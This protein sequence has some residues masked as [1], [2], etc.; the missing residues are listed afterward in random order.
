MRT[1]ETPIE[2]GLMLRPAQPG[3]PLHEVIAYNQSCIEALSPAFTTLWL[4]DHFQVGD[5]EHL[6]CL[7]TLTYLAALYPR[8]K[9]GSL[10]LGQGYRNPA[11]LAKMAANLQ[12]LSGGRLILG[13]GAGWKEDE[14]RAYGY[15]FPP[16]K[17]RMEQL[18]E[19]IQILRALWTTAPATFVGR[20]Y[21]IHDAYC[22]PHPS[23]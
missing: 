22:V 5:S 14:Y 2:F 15:T 20:H 17:T 7:T 11:L 21:S 18:E 16:V 19:A 23:P 12:A 3:H 1:T 10:V 8:L 6:E 9:V 13:L 4:E